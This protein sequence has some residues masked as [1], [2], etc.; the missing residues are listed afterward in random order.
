MLIDRQLRFSS[1]QAITATA[2][3]TDLIDL[4][5]ANR[6]MGVGTPHLWL[7]SVVTTALT[8]AASNSTITVSLETDTAAAFGSATTAQTCGTFAALAAVGTTIIVPVQPFATDERFVRVMYTTANGDL[9]TGSFTTFLTTD[10]HN[11]VARPDGS[12]IS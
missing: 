1:E 2:A 11:W 4:G 3:S 5:T 6:D 12:T 9:T 10:P 8:D 7:V